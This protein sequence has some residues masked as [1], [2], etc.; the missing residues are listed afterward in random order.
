M[1]RDLWKPAFLLKNH[2]KNTIELR[3]LT[4]L[5]IGLKPIHIDSRIKLAIISE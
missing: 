5:F 4:C 2:F 1:S 3:N